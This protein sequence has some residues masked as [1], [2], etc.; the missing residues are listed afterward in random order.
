[1][2]RKREKPASRSRVVDFGPFL[3]ATF[4]ADGVQL[5][6]LNATCLAGERFAH[7]HGCFSSQSFWKAGSP[8]NGSQIGSSLPKFPV[9]EF[10]FERFN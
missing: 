1:M 8:R 5:L 10:S 3:G 9:Y 7:V 6:S 4:T 2:Q